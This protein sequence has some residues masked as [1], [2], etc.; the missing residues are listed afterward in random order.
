[1]F[2]NRLLWRVCG[3]KGRGEWSVKAHHFGE[4]NVDN[5]TAILSHIFLVNTSK[6]LQK[7]IIQIM[8]YR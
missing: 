6:A 5:K 1:V 8:T 7:K 2:K 3:F 4:D